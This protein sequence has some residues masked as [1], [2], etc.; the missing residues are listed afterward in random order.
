MITVNLFATYRLEAGVKTFQ[1]DVPEGT[2]TGKAILNILEEYPVLKKHWLSN[3][4]E[5]FSHVIVVLNGHDIYTQP[6][7]LDTPLLD[8][9]Q[10]GFFPPMAGG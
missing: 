8:G 3:E 4:G 10:L 2:T 9:D 7:K 5:L 1:L 6:D